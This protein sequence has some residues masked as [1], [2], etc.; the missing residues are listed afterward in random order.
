MKYLQSIGYKVYVAAN[1][2]EIYQKELRE[3]GFTCINIPFN[4]NPFNIQNIKAYIKLKSLF[5]EK[6]FEMLHVHTPVAAFLTRI[7]YHNYQKG[8]LVYTAHGFHFFKGASLLNWITY[9][10]LEIIAAKWTDSL[11]TINK[12]DFSQASKMGFRKGA[13]HYV[14]GVGVEP[15]EMNINDTE[16]KELR[17]NIGISEDSIVISYVAEINKNKNHMFL[18]RNWRH[19]KDQ[20]PNAVLLIIGDGKLLPSIKKFVEENLL[21]D[22]NILGHRKDV[23]NL[24]AISDIVTLLSHREGLPKSIMEAM[25]A[26]LPCVVTDTRGLR[27]LIVNGDNGYVVPHENNDALVQ[28]FISLLNSKEKRRKM[29]EIGYQNIEPYRLENVLKEYTSIYDKVLGK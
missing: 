11:I 22:I 21:E 13:V 26:R 20:S 23:M 25:S 27:D 17:R 19:I 28:A 7:A 3:K 6:S 14:H 18:L 15:L 16:I 2:D 8:K 4:R 24:L 1:E 29:G 12:E 5:T 10:P 9:Y